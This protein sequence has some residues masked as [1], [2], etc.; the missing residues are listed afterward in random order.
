MKKKLYL[1][2]RII[3]TNI[4]I[5]FIFVTLIEL[6]FGYWFDKDNFGP[7]MREHRMKKEKIIWESED[8]IIQY[9]YKKN[10]YGF[11]GDDIDPSK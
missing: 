4:F 11:R 7:Y 9:D 5:V 3:F 2:L 8:E 1:L 10:Y 6:F